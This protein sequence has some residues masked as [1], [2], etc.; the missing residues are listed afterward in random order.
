[1]P[2]TSGKLQR[3]ILIVDDH[4]VLRDGVKRILG[5]YLPDV[6][7]GEAG[8]ASEAIDRINQQDWDAAIL[9]L[10]LGGTSGLDV[11]KYL[12]Q[13]RP[14]TP[15]LV[16]SMHAEEQYAKRAF[17]AGASGYINKDCTRRELTHALDLV[18][19]GGRYISPA[20]AAKLVTDIERGSTGPA[21][22][23]L[24]NREFEV[25]RLIA[26]GR[27]VTQIA[28]LLCLSDKTISTY[29]A[30]VLEKM[31]MNSNA[32]LTHYTISNNLL[33]SAA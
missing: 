19:N 30:R 24:S 23:S 6:T 10:S 9:D 17:R 16:L 29:R 1:M 2:L 32:E 12:K 31:R 20:F 3:K 26:S 21:H 18:T 33:T 13:Y 11:L 4:E 8:T 7:F 25:M 15:A 27:T 5:D 28:E 22:E 14:R